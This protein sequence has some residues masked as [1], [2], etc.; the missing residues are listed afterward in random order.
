MD[1]PQPLNS[2]EISHTALHVGTIISAEMNPRAKKPAYHMVIDFG[3]LGMK[4]S[5]AQITVRYQTEDLTGRQVVAVT[6]LPPKRIAGVVSEVLVLGAEL[7]GN[8]VILL[9]IDSPV[10]NGTRI[11]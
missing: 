6:G 11:T 10:P 1:G 2:E 3:P 9:N 8:D 5:S 4:H 7:D